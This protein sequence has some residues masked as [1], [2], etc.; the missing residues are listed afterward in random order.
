MRFY[1]VVDNT[2][3]CALVTTLRSISYLMCTIA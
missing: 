3:V 1:I 2:N